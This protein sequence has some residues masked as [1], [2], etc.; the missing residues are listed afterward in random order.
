MAEDNRFWSLMAK[1]KLLQELDGQ[2][3][4]FPFF[5]KKN[6][7]V[8]Q[9]LKNIGSTIL[10]DWT[11][12]LLS[13]Q[14]VTALGPRAFPNRNANVFIQLSLLQSRP[15]AARLSLPLG[16]VWTNPLLFIPKSK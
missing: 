6:Y 12:W 11:C 1:T 10:I 9:L 5:L 7:E 16:R 8:L 14:L 3:W 2:K 15:A 4:T 13:A